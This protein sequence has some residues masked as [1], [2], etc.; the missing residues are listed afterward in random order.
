[1]SR[2][3]PPPVV[4]KS[5]TE[6]P[7]WLDAWRF[8]RFV[9]L[10]FNDPTA[11]D[12]RLPGS[13]LKFGF[14]RER[15]RKWDAHINHALLGKHWAERHADRMFA[16]Y[17]LE[18]VNVNPHWHGLIRFFNVTGMSL[19][20]QER[21]FDEQAERAWKKLVPSGTVVVRPI[22][23]HQGIANYVAKTLAYPLSYEFY[24][25]PDELVRG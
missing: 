22:A 20:D 2:M 14:L 9:T 18:K 24:V 16:F 8:S 23:W 17:V 4:P 1:M 15:L 10:A 21:M 11:A 3:L 13:K 6:I 12:A 5:R 19:E 7:R 25:T